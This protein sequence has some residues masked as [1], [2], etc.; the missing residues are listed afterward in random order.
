MKKQATQRNVRAG[1]YGDPATVPIAVWRALYGDGFDWSTGT[2]GAGYTH[3]WKTCL[4][5]YAL[6]CMA[7]VDTVDEQLQATAMDWRTYRVDVDG[8]GLQ[9]G[10]I[11]CPEY[12]TGG[13]VTCDNCLLCGGNRIASKNIVIPP[14]NNKAVCYVET[15][16]APGAIHKAIQAGSVPTVD[17]VTMGRYLA[18]LEPD[19]RYETA[20]VWRGPSP[21]DGEAIMLVVTGASPL[22]SKQSHNK[23]TGPMVQTWIL[24]EKMLPIM[25]VM[26]GADRSV[27]GSCKFRPITVK[28]AKAA[29]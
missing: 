19:S 13:K 24:V 26:S 23:K 5:E 11:M 25:A 16:K 17:P 8:D 20:I 6:Y 21:V 2:R 4:A 12:T 1:A 27:C 15:A 14:I 10:E 9:T 7:S 18:G 28:A 3:M 29:A 22:A